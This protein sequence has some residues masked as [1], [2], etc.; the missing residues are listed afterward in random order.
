MA[1]GHPLMTVSTKGASMA[2]KRHHESMRARVHES[3]GEE[4]YEHAKHA[5]EARQDR[6]MAHYRGKFDSEGM[7]HNDY[8]SIANMPPHAMVKPWP[9]AEDSLL[10][11]PADDIR[12]IDQQIDQSI[13]SIER[14]R[15]APK[16]N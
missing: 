2:K 3:M 14:N 16:K 1:L 7:I 5:M 10:S 12:G 6:R 9:K 8:G 13:R 4:R 11:V 15:M